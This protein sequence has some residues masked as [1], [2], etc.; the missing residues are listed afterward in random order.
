MDYMKKKTKAEMLL[1]LMGDV[2]TNYNIDVT[3]THN[4]DDAEYNAIRLN[5]MQ[6]VARAIGMETNLVCDESGKITSISVDKKTK[7]F[8]D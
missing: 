1:E 3:A 5:A 4:K 8:P 6:D 7:T 2:A